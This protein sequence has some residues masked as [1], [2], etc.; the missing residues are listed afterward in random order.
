MK[1]HLAKRLEKIATGHFREARAAYF[2][3]GAYAKCKQ[4]ETKF[5]YKA[6]ERGGLRGIIL[7]GFV[8]TF[9]YYFYLFFVCSFLMHGSPA[10]EVISSGTS[11]ST[12]FF[13][14]LLY[15]HTS[16]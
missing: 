10:S 11:I 1:Y 13:L 2:S 15:L 6:R 3:W 4:L 7:N 8:L 16:R 14:I 5:R 9:I 12:P